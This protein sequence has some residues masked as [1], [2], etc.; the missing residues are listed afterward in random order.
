MTCN[1]SWYG[2]CDR[3]CCGEGSFAPRS[4]DGEAMEHG[5][6]AVRGVNPARISRLCG[7]F[8]EVAMTYGPLQF[9]TGL[10]ARLVFYS[11]KSEHRFLGVC[12][13]GQLRAVALVDSAPLYG[14]GTYDE[15]AMLS[16]APG[17]LKPSDKECAGAGT[18]AVVLVAREAEEVG[19]LVSVDPLYRPEVLEFYANVE[20]VAPVD[21]PGYRVLLPDGRA[22]LMTKWKNNTK[23]G[24]TKN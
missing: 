14:S 10:L 17:N 11:M 18:A 12:H 1:W 7:W 24:C 15:I 20:F 2:N 22:R 19:R 4:R 8:A 3:A 5:F 16:A 6:T 21:D 13:S 9:E 23:A